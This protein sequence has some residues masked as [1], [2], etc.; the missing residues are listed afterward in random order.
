MKKL[1]LAVAF[2]II[3]GGTV[4]AQAGNGQRGTN[5]NC[6]TFVDNNKDGVC[7]YFGTGR[8]QGRG[9]KNTPVQNKRGNA[10]FTGRRG[11]GNGNCIYYRGQGG[12]GVGR[13]R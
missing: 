10:T 13:A 2:T 12:R 5:K 4:F 11:N 9:L 8:G 6:P 7:D 3:A 1:L